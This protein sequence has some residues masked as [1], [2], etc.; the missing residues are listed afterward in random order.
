[1]GLGECRVHGR[2]GGNPEDAREAVE[3]DIEALGGIKLRDQVHIRQPGLLT[4]AK[5]M[6]TD[7]LLHRCQPLA[8]PMADPLVDLAFVLAG[9][10]QPVEHADVV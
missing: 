1:M 2:Q 3:V 7:Q 9:L 10:A 4:E 6:V 8:D 5:A